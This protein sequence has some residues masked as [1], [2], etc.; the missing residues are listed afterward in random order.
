MSTQSDPKSGRQRDIDNM[1]GDLSPCL[2]HPTDTYTDPRERW[3][4]QT[5]V[6][7]KSLKS[8]LGD[9][10][11]YDTLSL[12]MHVHIHTQTQTRAHTQMHTHTHT[13]L[14]MTSWLKPLPRKYEYQS[15]IPRIQWV[16]TEAAYNSILRRQRR[17]VPRGSWLTKSAMSVSS[18]MH[19]RTHSMHARTKM[20]KISK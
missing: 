19:T 10:R 20:E 11:H 13:Q 18:H 16:G 3:E 8:N 17:G 4:L 15:T 2:S 5:K 9:L 14:K 6:A 1:S 12:H 7:S